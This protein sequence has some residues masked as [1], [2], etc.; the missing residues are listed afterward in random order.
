ML[1][2]TD[3]LP[4]GLLSTPAARLHQVL[5]GPTLI[6]VPGRREPPLFISTLLHGNEDSGLQAVQALLYRYSG[7]KDLPRAMSLFIGNVAAARHG[8]R[9]L[10]GQSDFNRVWRGGDSPEHA[11]ARQVLEA[12]RARGPFASVDVHNNTGL[13]PHYACVNRLAPQFL[14]LATL[15]SRTVVYF[16]SPD[17]VQSRA[18]AGLCPAVTLE[19]GQPG[20]P[21][22]VEHSLEYLDA[23]LRLSELPCHPVA[24]HDIDLFHTVATVKVKNGAR[25]GFGEG[26]FDIRF[27][28]DLDHLNFQELPE[29]ARLGRLRPGGDGCLLD[30][31]DEHGREVCGEYFSAVDGEL[32][33]LRPVMPSMLTLNRTVIQQDCLCYLMERLDPGQRRRPS[34]P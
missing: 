12:M 17:T 9:R 32:R 6:H 30:V 27:E 29:G 28:P 3:Q 15:F 14:H 31:R 19:C 1:T 23:C 11:M 24:A 16:T 25:F 2:I 26:D 22:G 34:A 13:N 21:H 10:D 4:A 33:T 7:G 5:A 8:L 18:F 20:Q